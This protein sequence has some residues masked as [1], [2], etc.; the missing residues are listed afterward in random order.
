MRRD[1]F[2]SESSKVFND[3][4]N[5]MIKKFDADNPNIYNHSNDIKIQTENGK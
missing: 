3:D 1:V 2:G 4:L 5:E